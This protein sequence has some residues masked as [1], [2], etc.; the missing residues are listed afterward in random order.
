M[1]TRQ[2]RKTYTY[3]HKC[4]HCL[5]FS[6]ELIKVN[7]CYRK[8]HVLF[9]TNTCGHRNVLFRQVGMSIFH[10]INFKTKSQYYEIT[11]M[12]IFKIEKHRTFIISKTL[13]GK[14]WSLQIKPNS[15][16][17]YDFWTDNVIVLSSTGFELINAHPFKY[18]I[19][20]YTT[21]NPY[22]YIQSPRPYSW[23]YPLYLYRVPVGVNC[24]VVT[25]YIL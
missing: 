24:I 18:T 5:E 13:W 9:L 22:T 1:Q 12:E 4:Q 6:W 25:C 11:Y 3:F 7:L 2:N 16:R 23:P 17:E 20:I 14:L 15:V 19:Y 10:I 21:A 8:I